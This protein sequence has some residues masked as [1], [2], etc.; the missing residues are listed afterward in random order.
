MLSDLCGGEEASTCRVG[1]SEEKEADLAETPQG[2]Q[3]A[4]QVSTG[5]TGMLEKQGARLEPCCRLE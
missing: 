3:R 4:F 5:A 2:G 1:G